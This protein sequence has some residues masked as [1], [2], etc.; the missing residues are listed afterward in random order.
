MTTLTH[1]LAEALRACAESLEG[2]YHDPEQNGAHDHCTECS[3]VLE[4]R[5]ILAEYDASSAPLARGDRVRV[6]GGQYQSKEY[7]HGAAVVVVEDGSATG[8][9]QCISESPDNRH[10]GGLCYLP[11]SLERIA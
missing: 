4:A 10:A 3:A 2:L 6:W 1:R 9:V 8:L 7:G 5:T 11:R